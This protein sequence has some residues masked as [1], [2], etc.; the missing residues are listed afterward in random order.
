MKHA[1]FASPFS[2]PIFQKGFGAA[3][4]TIVLAGVLSAQSAPPTPFGTPGASGTPAPESP[5]VNS[6]KPS[7]TPPA[8]S[9]GTAGDYSS[10]SAERG[11]DRIFDVNKDSV[12]LENGTMQWKGKTFNLGNSRVLRARLERYFATPAPAGDV[13]AHSKVLSE[14]EDLLS[15]KTLSP[16][17]YQANYQKAWGLLFKAAEFEADAESCLT[18]ATLVEKTRRSRAEVQGLRMSQREQERIRQYESRSIVSMAR[19]VEERKDDAA[20]RATLGKNPKTYHAPEEGTAAL[21]ARRADLARMESELRKTT[22]NIASLELKSRLEF[23]SQIV[24]F[25]FQR[26]FK[27]AI[28]ASAFYRY[29]F[30]SSAHELKVG[31][32]QIKEMLPLNNF[33][34]T[35]DSVD[36]LSREAIKDVDTG[37]KAVKQLYDMGSRYKA[38]ERLQETFFLGEFTPQVMFFDPDKKLVLMEIWQHLQNL[39]RMGDERDLAGVEDAVDKVKTVANDFPA[40]SIMSRVNNARRMSN[41]AVL[42]AKQ[43]AFSGDAQRMEQHLERAAKIWPMNPEI[44]AFAKMAVNRADVVSQKVPEFDRLQK[45]KKYREIF[46]R[47]EEFAVALLQDKERA[48]QLQEI[49]SLVGK[50]DGFIVS[51]RTLQGQGN[52]FMAWDMLQEAARIGP[53]DEAVARAR[54]GLAPLVADYARSLANAD[55]DETEGNF[56]ASLAWY[57][58]AQDIN[59]GSE[60]CRQGIKRVSGQLF[61]SARKIQQ[62]GS[63]R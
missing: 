56:A 43:A 5:P 15:P 23:Q 57:L 30:D 61:D 16:K 42:S 41:L 50:I 48:A 20:H 8:P 51:A 59:P 27:H 52:G 17:N 35:I 19:V 63:S 4:F 21:D 45:G 38:L 28:I 2:N 18:I 47:K 54:A 12:D 3:L 11:V 24:A 6:A 60:V 10:S 31:E 22:A 37:I 55:R 32:K 58:A 36:M 40:T 46:N 62:G 53:D 9:S 7:A 25:L 26:R 34:P 44:E 14:I 1:T 39:Q 49:L 33:S 29:T 13:V